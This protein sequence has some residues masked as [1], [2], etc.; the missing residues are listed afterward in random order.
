MRNEEIDFL[1]KLWQKAKKK[2]YNPAAR[3]VTPWISWWARAE[4][5][6]RH[7][8]FQSDALPTEL[9]APVEAA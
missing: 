5:N 4:L 8:D 1:A 6:C 7:S 3:L 9:P 2:G